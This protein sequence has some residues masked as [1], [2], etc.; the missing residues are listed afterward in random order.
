VARF[1]FQKYKY[2]D[3]SIVLNGS[4]PQ[5]TELYVYYSLSGKH[6]N[7]KVGEHLNTEGSKKNVLTLW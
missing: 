3:N 5:C 1:K 6:I 7:L 2:K 4:I